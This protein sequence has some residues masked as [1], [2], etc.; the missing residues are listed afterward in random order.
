M[1][2]ECVIMG[3]LVADPELRTTA[4][5]KD[6]CT[7][8]V[9]VERD[10]VPQGKERETD[11][12]TCVAWEKTGRFISNYFYKGNMIAVAGSIQ[13]RQYE[14]KDGNK[15]TATEILVRKASFAGEKKEQSED[16]VEVL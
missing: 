6:V 10:Y 2:N 16:F 1:L 4:T 5:G 3:R 8:R 11:F 7:I 9:A 13:N 14:D 15:R 12:I